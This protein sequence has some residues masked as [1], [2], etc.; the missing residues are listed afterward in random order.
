MLRASS[1]NPAAITGGTIN[2]TPIG[3]TTKAAGGFTTLD[4]DYTNTATVG[5]VTIN[6]ASGRVNIAAAGTSVIVTNNLVTAASHVFAV[7]SSAD[8]TGR[9]ISVVPAAGSFT[10][11]IVANTAQASFDFV[12]FN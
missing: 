3:G 12:V 6:K 10:I 1:N 2:N 8:A 4:I 5:A 9:V 11:N 7:M